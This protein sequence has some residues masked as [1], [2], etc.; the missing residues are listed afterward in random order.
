M[1]NK[2]KLISDSAEVTVNYQTLGAI[3]D[4]LVCWIAEYGPN[5]EL[6]IEWDDHYGF[7]EYILFKREE[8]D[9]EYNRRVKREEKEKEQQ[10]I[11][12]QKKEERERKEFERLKKKFGEQ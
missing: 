12:K 9:I 6:E 3:R 11:A 4:W 7:G 1:A 5:A 8:T 10:K 2:K